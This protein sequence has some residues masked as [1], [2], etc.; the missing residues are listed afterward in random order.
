[1]LSIGGREPVPVIFDTGTSG[2]VIDEEMARAAGLPNQGAANLGT[3]AGGAPIRGFRTT[4]AD[5]RLGN[6]TLRD[7][8]A[9]A[10]RA[11]FM[12]SLS[13]RGVFGPE[14]FRGRLVHV[15]LG[16]GE[17]R[18]TDKATGLIPAGTAFPYLAVGSGHLPGVTV[19]MGG[20]SYEALIDTGH[21]GMLAF[22]ATMANE[23]PLDGELRPSAQP[24]RLVGGMPR[25]TREGRIR[26]TVRIGPLSFENPEARFIEGLRHVNVGMAAL[27]GATLVIDPAEHRSWIVSAP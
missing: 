6:A 3:P 20:R 10:A 22:P 1:M 5:G 25:E 16:R 19:E 11:P 24:A 7:V 23:L 14:T 4:I 12:Q 18:I 17:I 27:R 15:D 21:A 26:G 8:P 13:V 2:N 9:T